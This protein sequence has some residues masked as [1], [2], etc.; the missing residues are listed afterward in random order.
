M[1]NYKIVNC[2]HCNQKLKVPNNKNLK[3][4]CPKCK[5]VFMVY[6]PNPNT[7]SSNNISFADELKNNYNPNLILEK[8]KELED[9]TANSYASAIE[10]C[11]KRQSKAVSINSSSLEGYYCY[12]DSPYTHRT[13]SPGYFIGDE[14]PKIFFYKNAFG[15]YE[16]GVDIY[17]PGLTKVE[18]TDRDKII[19]FTRDRLQKLGFKNI[20]I[21]AEERLSPLHI[22]YTDFIM[23]E[24]YKKFQSFVIYIK[25]SW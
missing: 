18:E 10:I 11:I 15:R 19:K 20:A 22:G 23:K 16:G 13:D 5:T 1:D 14:N 7:K 17:N 4:T 6:A 9:N 8:Q 3:V 24:R 12:G 25:V 21:R 2:A